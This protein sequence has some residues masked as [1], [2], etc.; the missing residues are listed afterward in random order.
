LSGLR[1]FVGVIN[2]DRAA[3]GCFITLVPVQ[4]VAAGAETANMGKISVEGYRFPRM[5][6]WPIGHYFDS[7]PPCLPIMTDPYTGKPL[8][9]ADLFV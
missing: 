1:D 6:I 8:D 5:Q 4:T 3:L 9:Q 2:R 7:R